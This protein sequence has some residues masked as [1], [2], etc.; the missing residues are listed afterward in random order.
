[1]PVISASRV[2]ARG[3][4]MRNAS[5]HCDPPRGR[6]HLGAQRLV[7][8]RHDAVGDVGLRHPPASAAAAGGYGVA[9]AVMNSAPRV[10]ASPGLT[11]ARIFASFTWARKASG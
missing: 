11:K 7:G 6:Q 3:S 2:G 8:E 4:A 10:S 5:A 9:R 1:M